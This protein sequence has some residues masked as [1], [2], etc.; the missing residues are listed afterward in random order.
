MARNKNQDVARGKRRREKEKETL[1]SRARVRKETGP[2]SLCEAKFVL[3][4]Q[5]ETPGTAVCHM[6][7]GAVFQVLE[8]EEKSVVVRRGR[9]DGAHT[10]CTCKGVNGVLYLDCVIKAIQNTDDLAQCG[11]CLETDEDL[12]CVKVT[13]KNLH[14]AE[15]EVKKEFDSCPFYLKSWGVAEY[16]TGFTNWQTSFCKRNRMPEAHLNLMKMK[17]ER[18][19]KNEKEGIEELKKL[20]LQGCGRLHD[21]LQVTPFPMPTENVS[22]GKEES[23]VV[24][25]LKIEG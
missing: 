21:E 2:L 9:V 14:D 8:E 17:W 15:K 10:G 11:K 12:I 18:G 1:A 7:K 24:G 4:D 5:Y 19:V 20:L 23:G 13:F 3:L 16:P 25:N 6:C 22:P